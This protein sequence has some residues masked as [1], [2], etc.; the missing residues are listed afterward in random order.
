V[1]LLLAFVGGEAQAKTLTFQGKASAA[2]RRAATVPFTMRVEEVL[3][4]VSDAV[5]KGTPLLR[6]SLLPQDARHYQSMLADAYGNVLDLREKLAAVTQ[7]ARNAS[8]S[9]KRD[10]ELAKEGLA[11]QAELQRSMTALNTAGMRKESLQNKL[12]AS[13]RSYGLILDELNSYFGSSLKQ[14][15]SLPGRFFL[16]APVAG[17]VI[18]LASVVRPGGFVNPNAPAVTVAVLNPIQAEIH[19]HESEIARMRKDMKV[20]IEVPDL[21]GR[22]FI[23]RVTSI[24]WASTDMTV[25]MP[26]FYVVQID[27]DNADLAIRPGY[28]VMLRLNTD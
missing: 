7:E 18:D 25:G 26:S 21:E 17:A 8:G 24:S 16:T 22:K 23:G 15:D 9:V 4:A 12:A 5:D 2:V 20:E 13:R 28:K 19:V 14:G 6:Y 11:P 1:A 10:R 3:V 27:I